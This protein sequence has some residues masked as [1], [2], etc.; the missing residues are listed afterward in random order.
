MDV[1]KGLAEALG[2]YMQKGN[3]NGF[4]AQHSPYQYGMKA[5]GTP[6]PNAYLYSRGGLFGRCDG[7]ADLINALVGPIGF[8]GALDW[9]G[10]DTEREFVDALA[11]VSETGNEQNAVCGDCVR[12]N[13]T[14][15]AQFYCFGRFC[16]Q[17]PELQFDRLSLKGHDGVPVKALFG[18]ITD[19][20]GN[21]LLGQGEMITDAFMLQSR[22]AGYGLR[23]KNSTMLWN[24]NPC[25]GNS[26]Y[27]EYQG[28]ELMINTGKVDAYTQEACDGLDSF[29]L[30]FNSASFT[31][32]GANAVTNWFK[33]VVNELS[34]RADRAGFDWNTANMFIVMTPNQWDCVAK[35]YACAGVD[36]CS[37][38]NSENEVVASADQA[39]ERYQGYLTRMSLPI[40]GRE[41]PV[42]LDS[43][44]TET[45]GNAN[46]DCSDIFFIT[47]EINGETVTFGQ[48]QNFNDTYG[49]ISNELTS[50]FG[51]DD[52]AITD[53]GRFALVRDNSRGCFDIQVYT[54]PRVVMRAPW[55]SGRIQNACCSVL[56]TPFPDPA[57]SGRVYEK[58]GGRSST[59]IPTLYGDCVDC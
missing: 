54:K 6:D 18:S 17:T 24:G 48:Y 12:V 51:S 29:L 4:T 56:G 58:S 43:Q 55:L 40:N 25:N 33:R 50:L 52:I 28:F 5:A 21:V 45:H 44:I 8:E 41:Y 15:C 20:E 46:G 27:Q 38:G 59:P 37:I 53:N 31:S 23:L 47:T 13:V 34:L 7:T 16:R 14:S 9:I 1:I 42:I 26:V 30:D 3:G 22:L 35:V 57:G 11:A 19:T 10:T 32:D 39:Q 49:T 2:P 36:L